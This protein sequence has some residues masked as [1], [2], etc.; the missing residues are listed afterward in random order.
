M[1]L[2]YYFNEEISLRLLSKLCYLSPRVVIEV[3]RLA[4]GKACIRAKKTQRVELVIED[5]EL[6][7]IKQK[8]KNGNDNYLTKKVH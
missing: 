7:Y 1:K 6:P 4:I 2:Q 5:F 3:I 8:V